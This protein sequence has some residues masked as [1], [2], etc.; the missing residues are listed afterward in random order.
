M[1]PQ[2]EW[3][4]RGRLSAAPVVVV[5]SSSSR[6]GGAGGAPPRDRCAARDH[7]PPFRGGPHPGP[8][9]SPSR[10]SGSKFKATADFEDA[11]PGSRTSPWDVTVSQ[12]LK[13]ALEPLCSQVMVAVG[14][15]PSWEAE[16][17]SSEQVIN[18]PA[19]AGRAYRK[20]PRHRTPAKPGRRTAGHQAA[21][22]QPRWRQDEGCFLRGAVIVHT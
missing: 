19:G 21:Q 3:L 10:P 16:P 8:A 22:P 11:N 13:E 17:G 18:K 5:I 6:A 4:C 2:H 14:R 20:G 12:G 1:Y 9:R 7:R 15:L